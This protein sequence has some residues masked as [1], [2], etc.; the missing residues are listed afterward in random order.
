MLVL[1]VAALVAGGLATQWSEAASGPAA[2]LGDGGTAVAGGRGVCFDGQPLVPGGSTV[3]TALVANTGTASGRFTLAASGLPEAGRESDPFA[4]ALTLEVAD[5]TSGAPR[6]V[7]QGLLS[8]LRHVDLGTLAPGASRLYRFT[9]SLPSAATGE[10][11]SL[12]VSFDWTA[13]TTA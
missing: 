5:V 10:G 3:G 6:V 12:S 4:R 2:L 8:G 1:T 9:V 7:Y 13:V 11:R